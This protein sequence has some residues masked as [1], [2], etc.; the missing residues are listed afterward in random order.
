MEN[1]LLFAEAL[2]AVAVIVN[3]IGYRQNDINRYRFVSGFAVL[4]LG[5]HFWL[6]GAMAASVACFLSFV[7]NLVA[8]RYQNVWI[9]VLFVG[10]NL[11]FFA[12]EWFILGHGW[13]IFIAYGASIIF[14]VGTIALKT[15]DAIR[16]WFIIAESLGL[17]YAL[18]VG[19]IFGS[20]FSVCNLASIFIKQYQVK[21]RDKLIS[22][23]KEKSS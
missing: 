1:T 23:Q 7:R 18:A 16:R 11:G 21:K 3:I 6:I 12:Y 19:S 8:M 4:S 9:V 14:T 15:A 5:F 17:I 10:L 13:L 20:V 2:G 22:A